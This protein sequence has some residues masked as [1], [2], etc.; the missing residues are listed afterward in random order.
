MTF[1]S[2]RTIGNQV[3]LGGQGEWTNTGMVYAPSSAVSVVG[4]TAAQIGS[5]YISDTLSI[6]GQ[7]NLSINFTPPPGKGDRLLNL[8]E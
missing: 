3:S 4:G 5:R 7:G 6:S 2:D 8:V 1:Y